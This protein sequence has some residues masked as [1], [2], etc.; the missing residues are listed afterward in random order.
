MPDED[1]DAGERNADGLQIVTV[2]EPILDADGVVV[3]T[4]PRRKALWFSKAAA[5]WVH[6]EQSQEPV[7]ELEARPDLVEQATAMLAA[8]QKDTETRD[9]GRKPDANVVRTASGRKSRS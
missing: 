7:P 5:P 3:A 6:H 4:W 1:A 9:I 2:A 8:A